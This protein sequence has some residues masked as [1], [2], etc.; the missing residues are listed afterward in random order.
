[1]TLMGISKL[2]PQNLNYSERNQIL[3]K[4]DT[5]KSR[6]SQKMIP[7]N[8]GIAQ[9]GTQKSGSNLKKYPNNGTSLYRD[10]CKLPPPPEGRGGGWGGG[11]IE[12]CLKWGVGGHLGIFPKKS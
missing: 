3:P 5:Q 11:S 8:P 6:N 7:K 4:N 10:I 1:M 12:G 9:K 2:I